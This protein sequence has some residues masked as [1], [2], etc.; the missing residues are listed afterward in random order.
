MSPLDVD[1]NVVWAKERGLKTP[2]P[3]LGHLLD[4]SAVMGE[5]YHRWLRPGLRSLLVDELGEH[6]AKLLMLV[7]GL[8]DIG[9]ANP[10]FQQQNNQHG[11][12]FT[13]IRENLRRHGLTVGSNHMSYFSDA[14]EMRRHE[15][16]SAIILGKDARPRKK[17]ADSWLALVLVGHHGKFSNFN[18]TRNTNSDITDIKQI[19]DTTPWG[20]I[21]KT[22]IEQLEIVVG[23]S[24]DELPDHVSPTVTV[25]ISGLV[26]L[27][28]RIASQ[29]DWTQTAQREMTEGIISLADPKQW[30]AHRA[31]ESVAVIKKTVG[32]YQNWPTREAARA[33]ILDG[34]PPRFAQ[35]AALEQG[36]G[37]WNVMAA[38]GSGKTEAALLRHATRDERLI[39]LLPTQATT[40]AIMRRVQKAF[41]GTTNVASLAHGLAI[42]E[43]FYSQNISVSDVMVGDNY[44]DN[45]G[46]FP[47][48]FVK[49]G[50]SR[51]L[52][53]VCVGTIDQAILGS[54]PTK[55]NHLRLLA[56]ANAHVVIDE[57]HTL[58]A[59]QSELLEDLL[60]WWAATHT[61]I[62][63]LTATMPAWQQEKFK[64]AYS[65][66]DSDPA[67]FPSFTTWLPR[68]ENDDPDP[69]GEAPVVIPTEPYTIDLTV[70]PVPYDQLVDSHIRW[71]QAQRQA[72]PQARIGIIC[73][74]VDRAQAIVQAFDHEKPVLLHSRMTAEHRRRNAEELEQSIG[75]N[76][77]ATT[78]LVVGTQAI[79]ASLDIDLDVLRTELCP[80]ESL[81]QRAGRLWRRDDAARADRV[82]GL[83]HKTISIA[84][85]DNPKEWQTKP[86]FAAQ[87]DRVAHW[88]AAL[89]EVEGKKPLRFPDQI[90]DF[91][92][93]SSMGLAE[94]LKALKNDEDDNASG[95]DEIAEL[96]CKIEAGKKNCIK[97]S[98]RL[99]DDAT[100]T[101]FFTITHKD[102]LAET[103]TRLIDRITIPAILHDP[104]GTI[105]GAWTGSIAAL[106]S[107]KWHDAEAIR[108]ALRAVVE[109]PDTSSYKAMTSEATDIT[110]NSSILCR[111]KVVENASRF[112]DQRLGLIPVKES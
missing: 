2:Y 5:L 81:I 41:K 56:L 64:Q 42:T 89:D 21:H 100:N 77:E 37:L 110:S 95:L 54:L 43:D 88:V 101:D 63:F 94:L 74:T 38:T 26:V 35:A 7:A 68:S 72:Y 28:D 66:H 8:H 60:H 102:E 92:N 49:S 31:A 98:M 27:A 48:E 39:F 4:T 1:M 112:Y 59:Y 86:Y 85:I 14:P 62:T 9:K 20:K 15:N 109:I 96:I 105:P 83:A 97:F 10:H 108:E 103:A 73:N 24:L 107:I 32:L 45:G 53:P 75:K 50:A 76:G 51:L 99:A 90:Q 106:N 46:L 93:Q 47:T 3:L 23:V 33:D 11:E 91:I 104:T 12:T 78:V 87:L 25:L 6:V 36:D 80:A 69:A 79:E 111:Y 13:A 82:P 19:F 44:Q 52:A 57:V 55:F 17:A 22:L 29:L 61:P 34:F 30:V 71:I 18:P 16:H 40:N 70:D 84:A 58:D 67:R 65:K